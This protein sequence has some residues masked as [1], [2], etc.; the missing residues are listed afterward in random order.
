M[1]TVRIADNTLRSASLQADKALSSAGGG[2]SFFG[3]RTEKY[4]N[5]ADLYSQ[6][7]NA[8]RVQKLSE[9]APRCHTGWFIPP[10]P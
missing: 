6:A 10:V 7:A 1:T 2:F 8:F 4:E 3:G 9:D 5:A